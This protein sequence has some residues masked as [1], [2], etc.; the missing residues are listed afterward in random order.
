MLYDEMYVVEK[1]LRPASVVWF[2]SHVGRSQSLEQPGQGHVE[3]L[4]KNFQVF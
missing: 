4:G 3:R 1:R 2:L